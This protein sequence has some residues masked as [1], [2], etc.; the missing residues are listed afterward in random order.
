MPRPTPSPAAEGE[1]VAAVR[2]A[3]ERLAPDGRLGVAVSGGGDS[4]ALLVLAAASL[5]SA[6]L[7]AATVDHGL[8]P[9]SA[10]EARAAGRVC[11]SLGVEHASLRWDAEPSGNLQ[12]AARAARHRL[13]GA[14]ARRAGLAAVLL[15]HTRD[16]QAETVLLRLARGSGIDGLSGMAERVEIAGTLW[17][18]PLLGVSRAALRE[19]L[20]ARGLTWSEDPSNAD[21]RFDRVRARQALAALGALG[22]DADGLVRTADRLRAQRAALDR[23]VDAFATTAA[24]HQPEGYVRFDR[25]ALARTAAEGPGGRETALRLFSRALLAVGGGAYRPD[26]EAA[27][28]LLSTCLSRQEGRAT[29]AGCLCEIAPERVDILREPARVSDPVPG[30]ARHWDGRWEIRLSGDP[31]DLEIGALGEA[32]LRC[33]A[34]AASAGWRPPTAWAQAPRAARAT[35]PALWRGE[36][37]L[38]VPLAAYRTAEGPE[39]RVRW[40]GI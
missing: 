23:A 21:P 37:L 20:I 15:G 33:L 6:R 5:G 7:A 25:S 35:T 9:E 28:R 26:Y 13:L 32:G 3:L 29:L 34:E 36:T 1:T 39:I 10:A 11:R 38:A 14:W 16:D 2:A 30:D 18:R 24:A 22:L 19:V 40:V 12:A 17:L 4:I 8:R 27:D 31:G